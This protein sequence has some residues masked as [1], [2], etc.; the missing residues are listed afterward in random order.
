[1]HLNEFALLNRL[2]SFFRKFHFGNK[3]VYSA[4][5]RIGCSMLGLKPSQRRRVMNGRFL[6]LENAKDIPEVM[7]FMDLLAVM[8]GDAG[9]SLSISVMVD[10]PFIRNWFLQCQLMGSQS[11]RKHWRFPCLVENLFLNAKEFQVTL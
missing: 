2:A 5:M 3:E 4:A 8:I 1:M 7:R 10:S 9:N 11:G 6:I